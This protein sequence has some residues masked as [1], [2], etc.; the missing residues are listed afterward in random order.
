MHIIKK[1]LKIDDMHAVR[2]LQ[3]IGPE[4]LFDD[5]V[6]PQICKK[7]VEFNA[8]EAKAIHI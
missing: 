6:H 7:I 1:V 8:F 5:I 2:K 4:V 3:R